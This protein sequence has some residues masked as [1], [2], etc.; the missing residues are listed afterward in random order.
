MSCSTATLGC[1][2]LDIHGVMDLS[3]LRKAHSQKWLCYKVHGHHDPA[4]V[5]YAHGAGRGA[6]VDRGLHIR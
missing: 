3:K 1:A 5:S 2:V 4:D 6:N